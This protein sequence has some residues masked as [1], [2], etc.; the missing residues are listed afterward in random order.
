MKT[1]DE[2]IRSY[3]K[4][5]QGLTQLVRSISELVYTYPK[6]HRGFSDEDGAELLLSFYPRIRRLINRYKPTGSSFEAYLRTTLRWQLRSIARGH[7]ARTLRDRV[8]SSPGVTEEICGEAQSGDE[9]TD[10]VESTTPRPPRPR[11]RTVSKRRRAAHRPS[12]LGLNPPAMAGE[13][14]TPGEAQRLLLMFLKS[15]DSLS[16]EH[17]IRIAEV[18]GCEPEWLEQ[19]R[20]RLAES[21]HR[22]A[23]REQKFRSQRDRAWFA[24][25]Y[26]DERLTEAV[27]E[28][29]PALI[30]K[31]ERLHDRYCRAVSGLKRIAHAPTHAQIADVLG[32]QK[33]TIDSSVFTAKR[34]LSNPAYQQRLATLLSDA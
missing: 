24:M 20:E 11:A 15:S 8:A 26:A 21:A 7:A 3:Q 5:G 31:R 12:V 25:R 9:F 29:R 23:P 13:G 4:T 16:E 32:V 19:C 22:Y 34:E 14:L 1:L 30:E 6:E 27:G 2:R 33:G 28:E 10:S 18:V 17:V